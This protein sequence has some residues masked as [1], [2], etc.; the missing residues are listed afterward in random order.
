MRKIRLWLTSVAGC[1]ALA[2][3]SGILSV[4]D[5]ALAAKG[6][7][8]KEANPCFLVSIPQFDSSDVPTDVYI[9]GGTMV[10]EGMGNNRNDLFQELV[11]KGSLTFP[12]DGIIGNG[13][14]D[15]GDVL[16]FLYDQGCDLFDPATAVNV[17]SDGVVS[18]TLNS[19]D[20]TIDIFVR[21]DQPPD[22][23]NAF[24]RITWHGEDGKNHQ[25][26]VG[27]HGAPDK[28][29]CVLPT[30]MDFPDMSLLLFGVNPV[31]CAFF[32]PMRTPG[33][34]FRI[35]GGPKKNDACR[36]NYGESVEGAPPTSAYVVIETIG[37]AP[38]P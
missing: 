16:L 2:V 22:D 4:P 37:P 9:P 7:K 1:L 31:T 28:N 30:L 26:M 11:G 8:K 12:A 20:H 6:G 35:T 36:W 32:D 15:I 23:F 21:T 5:T 19:G 27:G 33:Q 18:V 14:G 13:R 29:W 10:M 38:C 3:G 25:I 17:D 24:I 34:T